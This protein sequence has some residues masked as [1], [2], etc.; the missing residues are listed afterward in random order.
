MNSLYPGNLPFA[1]DIERLSLLNNN[2]EAVLWNGEL[3]KI[4][5]MSINPG[6]SI[7]VSESTNGNVFYKIVDGIGLFESGS[8]NTNLN[9]KRIVCKNAAMSVPADDFNNLTN[10]GNRTLKLYSITTLAPSTP[11]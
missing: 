10:V 7:G 1:I 3:L 8:S 11:M 4:T 9:F 2:K 5:L 6:E